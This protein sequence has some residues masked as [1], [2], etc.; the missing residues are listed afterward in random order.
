MAI[1]MIEIEK[2]TPARNVLVKRASLP[3]DVEKKKAKIALITSYPPRACGIATFSTDLENSLKNMFGSC[4]DTMIFPLESA[5]EKHDYDHKITRT[6]NK[7]NPEDYWKIAYQ[8][9]T[10]PDVAL[11]IIQHEFGL[12]HRRESEFIEFL[13][14]IQKPRSEEHTSELQSRGHL[15]CRL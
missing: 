10:N 2:L 3:I 5:H 9:N 14:I 8:I 7:D 15:V 4:L 6:L 1:E 11:V 12:F 13:N